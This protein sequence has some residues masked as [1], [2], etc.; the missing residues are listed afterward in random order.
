[1]A[2]KN[3]RAGQNSGT[4]L[5]LLPG[6]MAYSLSAGI[7]S[8]YSISCQPACSNFP[9]GNQMPCLVSQVDYRIGT[10]PFITSMPHSKLM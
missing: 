7:S 9:S 3:S 5:K 8:D 6:M 2:F 10:L 4:G 1:M